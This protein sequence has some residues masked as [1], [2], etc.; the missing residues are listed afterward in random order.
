MINKSIVDEARNS[1]IISFFEKYN[2]FVFTYRGGEY[3]CKQHPSLAVNADRRSWYWHSKG[4]GGYGVLDYL[5]K[6]EN[7]P[8]RE[9]VDMVLGYRVSTP[10]ESSIAGSPG[11]NADKKLVLPEKVFLPARLYDYLCNK[12]GIDGNIVNALLEEGRIYGDRRGNIVFV[13]F[14]E[15]GTARFGCVHGTG[16]NNRLRMD[17]PGSDKHF[18][19]HMSYSNT[20]SL[21]IFESAIDAMSHASLE[22]SLT[23]RKD[24]WRGWNRLSLDGTSDTAIPKYLE[25]YPNT[26]ELILCL[27]NDPPGRAAAAA[28]AKK[29]EELKYKTRIIRPRGK[30]FNDDLLALRAS[31]HRHIKDEPCL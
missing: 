8:F 23:A 14:D 28:I 2:G 20:D 3:R 4:A 12:R 29:Y 21:Y 22:N 7:V 30:D 27:D 18:G 5:T 17:C 31:Q 6:V 19:F 16:E 26:Y 9:A 10:R 25:L 13:G 24:T 11:M 15:N 1:D